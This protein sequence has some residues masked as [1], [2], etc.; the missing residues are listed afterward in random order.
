MQGAAENRKRLSLVSWDSLSIVVGLAL[1]GLT[2]FTAAT[3]PLQPTVHRALF[4]LG[5][6]YLTL[7]R[8]PLPDKWRWIDGLL[9]LGATVSIG[10]LAINWEALAYRALFEPALHEYLLGGIAIAVVLEL[11]RRAVGWPLALVA[12]LALLYAYFGRQLPD[13]FAHRGFSIDRILV[14][15]YLT[16]EG[17]FGSILGT[18][19]TMVSVYLVFGAILQHTGVSALF[20]DVAARASVGSYGGPAKVSIISSALMGTVT[21]SSTANV[22]T[23]GTTTIPTMLRAGFPRNFAPAI[24]AVSSAG[25][26]IMPPVMGVAAFLMAELTGIPYWDIALAAVIPALLYFV[27]V[28]FEVDLEARRLNLIN[29]DGRKVEIVKLARKAYLLLPIVVLC[30]FLF[31]KYSPAKAALIGCI[32]AIL[33]GLPNWRNLVD[34]ATLRSMV[35]D[36]GT[37]A[38]TVILACATAGIIVGVLSLTGASLSLS[39]VLVE[40]AGNNQLLLLIFVMILSILLGMGM[41]TPAAYAVA[42]AFAAPM[43][44]NSGVEI[45]AAHMFVLFY[46]SLSSITPPVAVAA[47]AAAGVA[48]ASP[49]K[50]AV[51]ATKL[52][53]TAYIVPFIFV[54]N[55]AFFIG[56]GGT[57]QIV[58]ATVT[59]LCG[60]LFLSVAVIGFFRHSISIVERVF[61]FVAALLLLQPSWLWSLCGLAIGIVLLGAHLYRFGNGRTR[62]KETVQS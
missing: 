24:E 34:P 14:S 30:Y 54:N 38:I 6:T 22:V 9:A 23:T 60:V 19:V 17:L 27:S 57:L 36:F 37:A 20:M 3:I 32:A 62:I 16:N 45:L 31:A 51:I 58:T 15:Q 7:L 18:A 48:N 61:F 41:P 25:G 50:T 59:A 4:L 47:Y 46:A 13:L 44:V 52:A 21:G 49:L 8:F 26:Q 29:T 28:F 1:I 12:V 35:R 40:L 5:V 55:N 39:Y 10:Y 33:V 42:A 53:L 2:V 11:T 56:Q 43:L